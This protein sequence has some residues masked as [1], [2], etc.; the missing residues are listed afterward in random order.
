MIASGSIPQ[1]H[2]AVLFRSV[3]TPEEK[4]PGIGRFLSQGAVAGPLLSFV[5]TVGA[6]LLNPTN[7][8]NF[9]FIFLLPFYLAFS[10]VFSLFPSL[11]IWGCTRLAGHRLS[12]ATRAGI[13]ML[14]AI[15]LTIGFVY[16]HRLNRPSYLAPPE[17]TDYLP[18]MAVSIMM[19][20]ALGVIIGSR[21]QPWREL[22]RGIASLPAKSR[23]LTG[24]TGVALRVVV[25]WGLMEGLVAMTCELQHERWSRDILLTV[26]WLVHFAF[27]SIIV[28]ARMRL[29]LLLP[30]AL[31]A[32][33]PVAWV[34]REYYGSDSEYGFAI[35]AIVY[36]AIWATFLLSRWRATYAALSALK[37]ELRYYLID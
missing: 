23:V 31:I 5:A 4:V 15:L 28:F 16:L 25:V 8:Y 36:L 13:G 9:F 33:V 21:L 6:I 3:Y 12:A 17:L 30:L 11:L 7:G 22:V 14:M 35:A 29:S 26:W 1:G 37:D 32:N 24:I 19:G 20:M 18:V 27:A 34:I 10:M 2:G